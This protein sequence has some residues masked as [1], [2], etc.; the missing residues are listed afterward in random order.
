VVLELTLH[1][2]GLLQALELQTQVLV[3]A[4]VVLVL[5]AL[6]VGQV[7]VVRVS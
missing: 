1:T 2:A 6:R 3:V 7:R 5:T 4:L